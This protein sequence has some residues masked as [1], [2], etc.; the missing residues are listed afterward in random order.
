MANKC[1]VCEDKLKRADKVRQFSEGFAHDDHF[2]E[3]LERA[4]DTQQQRRIDEIRKEADNPDSVM[5]PSQYQDI[6]IELLQF[7]DKLTGDRD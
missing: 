2:N 6:F 5:P 7:I 4:L 3:E 1:V